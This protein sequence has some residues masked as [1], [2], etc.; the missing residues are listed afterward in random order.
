[1]NKY[2][3]AIKSLAYSI[4]GNEWESK[5]AT[6]NNFIIMQELVDMATPMIP[7]FY[8]NERYCKVCKALIILDYEN[9]RHWSRCEVCGQ[10]L[11]W[12]WD[13]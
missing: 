4:Y 8:E 11:K 13:D 12:E 1:M 7:G 2:Q 3:E 10:V 5:V 9:S 6:N